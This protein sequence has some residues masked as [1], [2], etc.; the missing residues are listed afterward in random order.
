M[1]AACYELRF[2]LLRIHSKYCDF[3]P[4]S[5]TLVKGPEQD[6]HGLKI[7]YPIK[8]THNDDCARQIL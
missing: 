3:L 4:Q 7:K 2:V 1:I 6:F 8:K 5:D